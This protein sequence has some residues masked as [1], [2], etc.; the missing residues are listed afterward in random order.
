[1]A[2][3]TWEGLDGL[4]EDLEQLPETL[5]EAGLKLAD[6]AAHLAGAAIKAAYPE[7]KGHPENVAKG[8]PEHLRS[9]V[10]VEQNRKRTG[11]VVLSTA[12]YAYAFE[13]G[14]KKGAKGKYGFSAGPGQKGWHG[15]TPARPTFIPLR[16][17]YQ[18]G[19]IDALE[20]LM[21]REGLK[22]SGSADGRE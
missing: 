18:R 22:V 12:P 19:L 1:M 6:T 5:A 16:E 9:G 20:G 14:R 13:S 11:W 2:T 4:V 7:G 8:W 21:I 3:I 10:I 17:K 15:M